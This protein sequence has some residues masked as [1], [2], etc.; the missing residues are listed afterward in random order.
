MSRN[1]VFHLCA[2]PSFVLL[3]FMLRCDQLLSQIV[4]VGDCSQAGL[5]LDNRAASLFTDGCLWSL[6]GQILLFAC[7]FHDGASFQS[8]FLIS[9]NWQET[10]ERHGAHFVYFAM[11][12][13]GASTVNL[14]SIP[15]H[16]RMGIRLQS[17]QCSTQLRKST[18]LIS[19]APWVKAMGSV[20]LTPKRRLGCLFTCVS[21]LLSCF[22]FLILQLYAREELN[23][24]KTKIRMVRKYKDRRG[25]KRVVGYSVL[26]RSFMMKCQCW[27]HAILLWRST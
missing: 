15:L 20:T 16:R 1:I 18:V 21:Y 6:Q 9:S 8:S 12:A 17:W 11:G 27:C 22:C 25:R 4:Q 23:L 14:V 7:C 5:L 26:N 2:H 19:T 3:A 13:V 10:I 24:L